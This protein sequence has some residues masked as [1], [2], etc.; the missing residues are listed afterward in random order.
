MAETVGI[1]AG[2]AAAELLASSRLP[3]TT[4][5]VRMLVPSPEVAS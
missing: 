5:P 3:L 1:M 2:C 4:D